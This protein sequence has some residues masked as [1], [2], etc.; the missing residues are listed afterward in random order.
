MGELAGN[1]SAF[2]KDIPGSAGGKRNLRHRSESTADQIEEET[3]IGRKWETHQL[4][5]VLLRLL[6]INGLA[7]VNYWRYTLNAMWI[8]FGL[9][10]VPGNV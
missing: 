1:I 10:V 4:I 7:Y 5:L 2:T 3:S 9:P 6:D 8:L